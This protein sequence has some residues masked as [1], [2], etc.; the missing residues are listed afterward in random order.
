[1]II[2]RISSCINNV[3]NRYI[4][5]LNNYYYRSYRYYY[6]HRNTLITKIAEKLNETTKVRKC[7]EFSCI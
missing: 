6:Y 4:C 1:M 5:G 2:N 7:L 3:N